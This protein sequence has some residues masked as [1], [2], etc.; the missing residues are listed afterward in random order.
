MS[1]N[2]ELRIRSER[3]GAG[4]IVNMDSVPGGG[5]LPNVLIPSVGIKIA[6]DRT[7]ELRRGLQESLPIIA[8]VRDNDTFLDFRTIDPIYD[9]I[10]A[11]ALGVLS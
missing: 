9:E 1:D 6:G 3:V 8:R 4:E 2:D 7:A 5:T 11:N 10:V